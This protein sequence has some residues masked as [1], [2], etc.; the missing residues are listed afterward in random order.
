MAGPGIGKSRL[1]HEF[2]ASQKD[3]RVT[4]LESGALEADSN[5]SFVVLKKL[6]RN[7]LGIGLG[8]PPDA[9][10]A[11]LAARLQERGADARVVSPLLFVLD[12]PIEDRE[13]AVLSAADRARRA[14]DATAVL[15]S[16]EAQQ[17]PVAVLIEDLHWLDPESEAAIERIAA[18]ISYQPILLLVTYRPEYRHDWLQPGS[19]LQL[20][21]SIRSAALTRARSCTTS[22]ERTRASQIWFR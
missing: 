20:K 13:W 5:V 4:V 7:L 9:A 15:L 6:L 3:N 16:L 2:L 10:A 19:F 21:T 22:S 8:E 17:Q 18:S 12:L 1:A 11:K 14:R